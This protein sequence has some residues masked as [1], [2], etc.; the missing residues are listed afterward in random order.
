MTKS[1]PVKAP[2]FTT[3]EVGCREILGQTSNGVTAMGLLAGYYYRTGVT[4]I[5][6]EM[7]TLI[8]DGGDYY[9]WVPILRDDAGGRG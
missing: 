5:G 9:G 8:H 2:V 6:V 4:V 1:Y 3:R 7:V